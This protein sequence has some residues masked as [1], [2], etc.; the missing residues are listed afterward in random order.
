MKFINKIISTFFLI[1]KIKFAP[2]TFGSLASIVIWY[3]FIIYEIKSYFILFL[4]FSFVIGIISVHFYLLETNQKDPKEVIID[5]VVG[6]SI[7][8][9]A[10]QS[11]LDISIVI[12]A[13][14]SF[15]FFDILKIYPINYVESLPGTFGVMLDDILAGF[16]ALIITILYISIL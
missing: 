3:I 12:V 2:G 16:Y 7:P 13:F 15:R 1:G 6:Q 9:V 8:L 4:L 11:S 14:L 5:E 10:I